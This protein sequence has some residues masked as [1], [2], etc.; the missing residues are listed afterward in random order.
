MELN[1]ENKIEIKPIGTV[2]MVNG[3]FAIK[4]EKKETMVN[5]KRH[6]IVALVLI[7]TLSFIVN[8]KAYVCFLSI[9]KNELPCSLLQRIYWNYLLFS[10]RRFLFRIRNHK[11]MVQTY[12]IQ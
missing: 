1:M 8:K 12:N 11:V 10:A 3:C 7:R 6:E 2:E 9:S 5:I 4:I